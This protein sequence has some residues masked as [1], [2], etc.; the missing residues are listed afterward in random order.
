[1]ACFLERALIVVWIEG[2]F[3]PL[4]TGVDTASAGAS[5][6]SSTAPT[7][8]HASG[9]SVEGGWRYPLFSYPVEAQ[10]VCATFSMMGWRGS[11]PVFS[12]DKQRS[13]YSWDEVHGAVVP[14]ASTVTSTFL[15]F[16]S[17]QKPDEPAR[18]VPP[19]AGTLSPDVP[20]STASFV[21]VMASTTGLIADFTTS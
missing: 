17:Q 18:A 19:S 12:L 15:Q 2:G 20:L 16:S 6:P 7:I 21:P 1:M 4:S 10:G 14:L 8:R 11:A 5:P 3:E 13:S 9:G